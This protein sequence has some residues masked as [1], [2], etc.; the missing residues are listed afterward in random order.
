MSTGS[1]DLASR[2]RALR[3]AGLLSGVAAG[4]WLGA[5]EAPAKLVSTGLSP[6]VVSLVMVCGVFLARWSLPALLQG[7]SAVEADVRR[8]P[9]LVIWAILAGSLWSIANTLTV[10]AIRD[11]GLS[12]AFPLWNSNSLLGILWGALFFGELRGATGRQRTSVL[13]GTLAMCVGATLLALASTHEAAHGSAARGV[14]AALCA[15]A[16]W[17]TMYIPYRKAYLTG[18]SPLA[19]VTFFTVGELACMG[20]IALTINGVPATANELAG[21]RGVL[22]WLMLGG[23]VWVIG[24]LFQQY[25]AKYVGISRGIPLSNTNQLW[26]LLWGTLVFGELRRSGVSLPL[27]VAGSLIMAVGAAAVAL[28]TTGDTEHEQW[29]EAAEREARRYGVDIEWVRAR[30]VGTASA[31]ARRTWIDWT[32]VAISSTVFVFLA[33]QAETPALAMD[34]RWV[35]VL[36]IVTVALLAA[37]GTVLWR[38]TRFN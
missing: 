37:A 24:D 3:S 28:A 15:G 13:G 32:L 30:L 38:T 1:A 12:I 6:V 17:G 36:C 27:V 4:A 8:A 23:F 20:I 22:F 29:R 14:I 10:Y 26:G 16:L 18:M 21:A 34:L 35:A 2:R 9:H 25:A 33:R 7:T 19:F 5:A 11:V 31:P